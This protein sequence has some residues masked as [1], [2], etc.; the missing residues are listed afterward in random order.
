MW[1]TEWETNI[2]FIFGVADL[3]D[4]AVEKTKMISCLIGFLLLSSL[5]RITVTLLICCLMQK[6]L[7]TVDDKYFVLLQIG[8]DRTS[9]I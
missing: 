2:G 9:R 1:G 7:N 8:L 6:C 4:N 3:P 5:Y